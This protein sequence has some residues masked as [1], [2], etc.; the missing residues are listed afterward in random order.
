[1]LCGL[2]VDV[3]NV[4]V[5][6]AELQRSADAAALASSAF[7][8]DKH[9]LNGQPNPA[10]VADA[11]RTA[12]CDYVRLNPCRSV[13]LNLPRNDGN[14][15]SGDLVLGRYNAD[16]GVFDPNST[17][18]NSAYVR[19]RRD[20]VQNGPIPLY[21][22]GLVGLASVNA[23]GESAAYIET[24]ISG[25]SVESG[26]N[27]TCKL[28]PFSLQI[29]LWQNR[30]TVGSD[31]RT[32]DAL[33]EAVSAGPDGTY[34]IN[35]YPS[36]LGPGNFGTVDFGN[37]NNSTSDLSRQIL[38]GL[39]ADDFS[40]L[41][42]NTIQLGG[43]GVLT[44]NG[45]TGISAAVQADL[46]AIIGQPRILPLHATMR[47]NGE[48]AYFDIVAFVGVTIVDADLTGSL[49]NKYVKLQPCFTSDGTAIGG[50]NEGTT[51]KF[52]FVPPRLREVR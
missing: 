44:L 25:F 15:E 23:T 40:F 3:G 2:T 16:T 24:D 12:A 1:M 18:Y 35:L 30:A 19:A 32:H 52:I 31:D 43:N 4:Y 39:S 17:K 29:D 5:S 6:K 41:P 13:T 45:D 11:A 10:L 47:G 28:L 27:S 51:S 14:A 34:E 9:D 48:N 50:G 26:S 38:H 36:E 21:F 22:G 49:S 20:S 8:L 37:P 46:N 33:N 42:N 7:L